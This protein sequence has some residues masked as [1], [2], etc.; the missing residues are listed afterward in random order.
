MFIFRSKVGMKGSWSHTAQV[1]STQV[2]LFCRTVWKYSSPDPETPLLETS[3][4]ETVKNERSNQAERALV[5][6]SHV[7]EKS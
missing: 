3:P 7:A 1:E 5:T 6:A 4:R 2:R